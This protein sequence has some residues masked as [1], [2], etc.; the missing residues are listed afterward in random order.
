MSADRVALGA[1]L[2]VIGLLIAAGAVNGQL[3]SFVA[4]FGK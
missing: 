3:A 4:G 2:A 1:A